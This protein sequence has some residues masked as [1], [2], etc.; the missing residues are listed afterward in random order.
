MHKRHHLR[1]TLP[2][3]AMELVGQ[4]GEGLRNVVPAGAGKWLQTGAAIGVARTGTRAVSH[5]VRRNPVAVA[6]A[7]AGI[8]LVLYAVRRHRRKAEAEAAIEGKSR[9]IEAKRGAP[10]KRAA[11]ADGVVAASGADGD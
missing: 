1:D 9:R 10:R 6:A 4:L 2:D 11:N 5:V 3:K 7:A 8:G